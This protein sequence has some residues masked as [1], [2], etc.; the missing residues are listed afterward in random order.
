MELIELK[1]GK[2]KSA[3]L[4]QRKKERKENCSVA[5]NYVLRGFSSEFHSSLATLLINAMI[6]DW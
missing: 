3:L 5:E 6:P 4:M 2:G 1:C